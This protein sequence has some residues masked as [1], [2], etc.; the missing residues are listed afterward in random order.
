[1]HITVIT[2]GKI[3]DP[4]IGSKINDYAGR[5]S[6][7][8]RLDVQTIKD[9]NCEDEGRKL[10]NIIKKKNAYTIAL[11][12]EGNQFSSA[13]FARHIAAVETKLAFVIGGP[14]GLSN[15]FKHHANELLSLSRMTFSHEMTQ[16]FLLEQI[17]RAISILNN[18]SYHKG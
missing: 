6:H 5:I 4:H 1:M 15:E 14:F 13:A 17:Y 12:E 8:A 3:K 7:D 18:R 11:A 2:V 10:L 16:L 9:S